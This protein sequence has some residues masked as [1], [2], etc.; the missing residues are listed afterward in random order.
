MHAA[1]SFVCVWC[2]WP[3]CLCVAV[4]ECSCHGPASVYSA[5]R[6]CQ[7][8]PWRGKLPNSSALHV[9]GVGGLMQTLVLAP[10][11][12]QKVVLCLHSQDVLRFAC[13][14]CACVCVCQ[15]VIVVF[16][17]VHLS[18]PLHHLM[19]AF[20]K[21]FI[22]KYTN[23]LGRVREL[24]PCRPSSTP[25]NTLLCTSSSLMLHLPCWSGPCLCR[26]LGFSRSLVDSNRGTMPG[27][28]R[29][30]GLRLS[31]MVWRFRHRSGALVNGLELSG[32]SGVHGLAL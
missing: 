30:Y 10:G 31:Q 22:K 26:R 12:Q 21:C 9:P 11:S 16:A 18:P 13:A 15:C 2:V 4:Y 25:L 17:L 24:I 20:G 27:I 19:I 5:G 29:A 8:H 3:V 6:Q 1:V 23:I 7:P 28:V 32:V 14:P